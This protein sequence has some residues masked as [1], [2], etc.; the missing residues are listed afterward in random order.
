[1][2]VRLL[3]AGLLAV[4]LDDDKSVDRMVEEALRKQGGA[5]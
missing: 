3:A 5:G 4:P 2:E 1:M